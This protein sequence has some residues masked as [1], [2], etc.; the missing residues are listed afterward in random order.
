MN[1]IIKNLFSIVFVLFFQFGLVLAQGVEITIL[2]VNDSH[3][4]LDATGPKDVNLE[5]TLGG[6]SKAA[7]LI[8]T[9]KATEPNVLLLHAGDF[10]VGDLFYNMYFGVPELQL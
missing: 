2:H 1:T 10:C 3:S 4:H 5:G 8:G 7:T 9:I 6:I